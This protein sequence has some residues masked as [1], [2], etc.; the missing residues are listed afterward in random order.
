MLLSKEEYNKPI[1]FRNKIVGNTV[2]GL[3][4]HDAIRKTLNHILN[5]PNKLHT[6]KNGIEKISLTNEKR[7]GDKYYKIIELDTHNY[8]K[9]PKFILEY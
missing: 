3:K 5:N 7:E 1:N 9:Q 8:Y 2:L 6:I 4:L